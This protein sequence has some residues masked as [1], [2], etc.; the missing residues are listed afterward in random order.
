LPLTLDPVTEGYLDGLA[1]LARRD[2]AARNALYRRF[3][4]FCERVAL[5]LAGRHWVRLAE[6]DDVRH[7]GFLVFCELVASWTERGSFAGY[8]FAHFAGRLAA[9]VRRFEGLPRSRPGARR[10]AARALRGQPAPRGTAPARDD[11]TAALAAVELLA[12]LDP[13]TRAAVELVA[14][15][16]RVEEVAARLGVTPRTVRRWLR[17]LRAAVADAAATP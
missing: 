11:G 8:V 2:P 7:E 14:A 17:R 15:G 10:P 4:P 1:R 12:G 5:R 3:A 13:G 9:A 6:L 16:Y